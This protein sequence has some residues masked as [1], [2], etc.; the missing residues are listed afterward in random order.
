M[1]QAADS[2]HAIDLMFK[3]R[4][5]SAATATEYSLAADIPNL[6]GRAVPAILTRPTG[7][8]A[9]AGRLRVCV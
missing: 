3:T 6:C 4:C 5:S 1:E 9:R 7:P 8:G 2:S